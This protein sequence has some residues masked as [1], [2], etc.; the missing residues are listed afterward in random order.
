MKVK[1]PPIQPMQKFNE[2]TQQFRAMKV[3]NEF[4]E[5]YKKSLKEPIK[6]HL[7]WWEKLINYF[8]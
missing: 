5:E 4:V 3:Q 8:N 6:K 1:A 2:A 7:T